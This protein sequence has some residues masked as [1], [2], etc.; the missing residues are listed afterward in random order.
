MRSHLVA[1]L[2]AFCAV[3]AAQQPPRVEPE[4]VRLPLVI[5]G[6]TTEVVAHI[7]KPAGAGPFPLV[8]HSHGRA[9]TAVDRAKLE[10]PVP[11]GHGNYWLRKGVAVVAPVRPGYG[12]TGGADVENSGV[13]WREA[14]C[15]TDPDFTS[16]A[17]HA[18]RTV[19]AT[20]HWA[21]QQPWVRKDRILVQGQS[22][23]GLTTVGVAALN[24]PGVVGTV[25]FAG[26]SGGYP[27]VS[28]GKSCKPERL[29][30]TYREFGRLAKA[31]SL[32][33]YAQNDNYWGPDMPKAWHQAYA[34]GGSDTRAVFTGPVPEHDG[35]QLLLHGGRMWSMPLDEFVKKVGLTAR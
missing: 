21:L 11:V 14:E 31:P 1:I 34:E 26:G 20:Y 19:V 9:G 12:A 29:T 15:Y 27:E 33:L 25:N 16:V 35:H 17:V 28:P 5:E 18:R 32:W 22:V 7:Y 30:L 10:Y 6:K 4:I 8:I 2:L 24:L 3:A 13:R 23:G